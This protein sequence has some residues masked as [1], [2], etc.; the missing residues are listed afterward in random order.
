MNSVDLNFQKIASIL[1]I[2]SMIFVIAIVA[3]SFL[4]PIAFAT[5]FSILL[6][7]I[8]SW[9]ERWISSRL[10]AI[11][12]TFLIV[13]LPLLL[14]AYIFLL[15]LQ[16]LYGDF[17]TLGEKI[18]LGLESLFN[19][20]NGKLSF[21]NLSGEAWMEE[22]IGTILQGPMGFIG[23]GVSSFVSFAAN[24][25]LFTI[26]TFLM[27][28]Y[29]SAIKKFY[30]MQFGEK[31]DNARATLVKVQ[32]IIGKYLKGVF[33]VMLVL[34]SL[35]SLGL[36]IVGVNHPILWG[37]L[38]AVLAIIPYVGTFAGGLMVVLYTY[39]STG[40]L[41]QPLAVMGLF[42]FVQFMEGNLISPKIVGESVR[43][44]PL[45][46]IIALVIGGS[47]WGVAGLILAIP[48]VAILKIWMSQIPML[49]PMS[50]ILSSELYD[51]AEMFDEKFNKDRFRLF[52]F[53]KRKPKR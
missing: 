39:T 47:I 6:A 17:P 43:L 4:V 19:W 41:W 7:P 53:F 14:I 49:K 37:S 40:T 46:A 44:N 34:A 28:L 50:L 36:W 25:G 35:N 12:I 18:R 11:P 5:F 15:Q 42:A 24:F 33:L 32:N 3:K 20:L 2:I 10:I 52:N 1:F 21:T 22:N 13:G 48:G 30:L 8:C 16:G 27:L 26:Y 29:R 31:T 9:V 45:A 23:G 51:K 38:T